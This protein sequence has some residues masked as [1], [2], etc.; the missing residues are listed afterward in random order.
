MS[1]IACSYCGEQF[2]PKSSLAKYCT[3]RCKDMGKPSASGLTCRV[4]GDP[5]V[6][7][8]TS[9]PQGQAA[10]NKCTSSAHGSAS[11]IRSGCKCEVCRASK[12]ATMRD[13]LPKYRAAY[14]AK[15]GEHP[16][17][18]YR[19]GYRAKHGHN[20]P[21]TGNWI[22][23]KVRFELYERDAWLCQLCDSPIDREAHWNDNLAPSLDHVIPRSLGG[24]HDPSNLRTA[25]RSCN[26]A[27]GTT[28]DF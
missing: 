1:S 26:S 6:K 18:A 22:D 9:K 2:H 25:H 10:H 7:S 3:P 24:L 4:C 14:K 12:A 16:S 17:T 19:R 5:M 8:Q 20:P 15:N 21:N 23:D 27:R 11:M 28:I 13:Y